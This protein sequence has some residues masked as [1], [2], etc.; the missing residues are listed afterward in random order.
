MTTESGTRLA[1][2]L[3]TFGDHS[4]PHCSNRPT[5]Q[6][7]TYVQIWWWNSFT[8][9]SRPELFIPYCFYSDLHPLCRFLLSRKRKRNE[10]LRRWARQKKKESISFRTSINVNIIWSESIDWN[11]CLQCF[12]YIIFFF[13]LTRESWFISQHLTVSSGI[14]TVSLTVVSNSNPTA[15]A[16]DFYEHIRIA[17]SKPT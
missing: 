1:Q 10:T 17:C 8:G 11:S 6:Q 16:S 13:N 3:S 4:S 7:R 5:S 12:T 9:H 2:C 15:R 14:M